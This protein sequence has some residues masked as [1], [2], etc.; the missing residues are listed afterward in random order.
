MDPDGDPIALEASG[1][2]TGASF[3]DQGSGIGQLSWMPSFDQAGNYQV[4]I[5]VTDAGT[6]PE[7]ATE[8]FTITVGNVNRPPVLAPIGPRTATLGAPLSIA[9]SASDPDADGLHFGAAGL[10]AAATLTDHADGTATL[11]WTPGAADAG[12]VAITVTVTDDGVP[13]A[14]DA[15]Q[16]AIAV[17][18]DNRPPILDPIGDR[19]VGLG[20]AWTIGLT[21]TDPDGDGLRFACEGAPPDAQ[22]SDAGAGSAVLSGTGDP[23]GNHAIGCTVTDSGSPPAS[24]TEQFTLS[25]GAVNRPPVLDPI[26]ASL[27]GD[28]ILLRLTAHDPD[29]DALAFTAEGLPTGAEFVDRGDGTAELRWL[30]PADA[31][32]ETPVVFTVTDD[33]TPPESASAGF[34]IQVPTAPMPREVPSVR[35][36]QWAARRGRLGVVGGRAPAGASVEILDAASQQVLGQAT[37]DRRGRF[38][39][40]VALEAAQAP[41]AVA[42]RAGDLVGEA[43]R[44]KG[45]PA[46]CR[47]LVQK[48]KHER[49]AERRAQRTA[50]E[51]PEDEEESED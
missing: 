17:G 41:C 33:G 16:F 29:G 47:T 44:V 6:P 42:A 27:E 32:S 28:A 25:V 11:A 34:T 24:D 15:E 51:E 18:S 13:M 21:A 8:T 5:K 48:A 20:E 37:A 10:P 38:R 12:S 31:P 1:L 49:R 43:R 4:S 9:L 23:A 7:S 45:A 30:P 40:Q 14:S 46:Q 39:M 35:N 26:G 36:A 22:L 3:A 2:P 19:S 50:E